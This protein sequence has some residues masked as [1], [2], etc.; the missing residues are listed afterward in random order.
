MEVG[1]AGGGVDVSVT[2]GPGSGSDSLNLD[3]RFQLHIA[4]STE[5]LYSFL[6]GTHSHLFWI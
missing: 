2:N 4:Y 3:Q 1:G 6:G 5:I